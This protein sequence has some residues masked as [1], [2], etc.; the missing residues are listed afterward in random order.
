MLLKLGHFIAHFFLPHHTN[1]YRAKTLHHPSIL[2]YVLF[3]LLIQTVYIQVRKTNPNILGFATDINIERVFQLVNWERQKEGM[4][5][6]SYSM[7]LSGAAAE[8]AGDMFDKN[9]WAHISPTGTTPW[10][11]IVRNGYQYIY[12]GENLAKSFDTSE[13]VVMAWMNSPTHRVNILKREYTEIGLAVVNGRLNGEE[14]TLVVQE[15]GS[16]DRTL[17]VS[18][19]TESSMRIEPVLQPVPAVAQAQIRPLP[20]ATSL[21]RL[22]S[23]V[24]AEFMLVLLML[25]SV[26]IW[27]HKT[28]RLTGH[29]LAHIL[30]FLTLL[31][32]M[33][34]TGLGAIL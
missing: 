32:A 2:I 12:A 25:D 23:L 6:L 28:I 3:L 31:G 7:E 14:T 29:S 21:P 4:P 34:A 13:E 17:P 27:K 33:S 1:N 18:D 5:V 20:A 26:F 22:L 8:K 10:E 16:R 11:F 9:Y 30:F 19:L 15:F 24:L